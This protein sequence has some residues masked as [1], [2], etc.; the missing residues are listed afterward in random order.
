MDSKLVIKA[1]GEEQQIVYGEVYAPNRPDAHGEF[2]THVEIR[3]MAHQ[4]LRDNISGQIDMM[5]DNRVVKGCS[6]VESFIAPEDSKDFIPGSWVVGVHV[7]D[8]EVWGMIK[9]GEINGFSMEALVVKQPREVEVQIPPVVSGLTSK[10]DTD[11]HQHRFY[12][13]YGPNGEFHGGKTDV[14]DGH[15][16][17]IIAGT[18]TE[19]TKGHSHRFSSVDDVRVVPIGGAQ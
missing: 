3:K 1:D 11:S 7:P 19:V 6:V 10:S 4:F 13:A 12:V 16:H 15:S 5:H 9:K 8:T 14:V 18:H 17:Q 2:M